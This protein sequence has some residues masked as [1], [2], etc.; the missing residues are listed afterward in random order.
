[1]EDDA[2]GDIS[3]PIPE[4]DGGAAAEEV[5]RCDAFLWVARGGLSPRRRSLDGPAVERSGGGGGGVMVL[6]VVVEEEEETN[7]NGVVTAVNR[8]GVVVV[9]VL[10]LECNGRTEEEAEGSTSS[11]WTGP[12]GD[13]RRRDGGED[14]SGKTEGVATGRLLLLVCFFFFIPLPFAPASSSTSS[15]SSSS[16]SPLSHAVD[17]IACIQRESVVVG[18]VAGTAG[19]ST[20]GVRY[21]A[22]APAR[23]ERVCLEDKGWATV[24]K[25]GSGVMV[26]P[27]G[28]HGIFSLLR[29]PSAAAAVAAVAVVA[30]SSFPSPPRHDVEM[31]IL[32]RQSSP[33]APTRLVMSPRASS[34]DRAQSRPLVREAS[35]EAGEAR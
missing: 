14:E 33:S 9:V 32:R 22:T 11:V 35:W 3:T 20:R 7:E 31:G 2:E 18:W 5:R 25:N 12:E 8:C 10:L 1:M 13:T 4:G 16:L 29:M 24:P 6:V 21:S 30:S 27:K 26:D 34:C 23:V 28:S 17:G 15:S 19:A